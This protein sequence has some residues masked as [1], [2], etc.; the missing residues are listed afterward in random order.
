MNASEA[1]VWI[2]SV[3]HAADALQLAAE[4]RTMTEGKPWLADRARKIVAHLEAIPGVR[5]TLDKRRADRE[6]AALA[7]QKG[8][9]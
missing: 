3:E 4:I 7:E 9:R 6:A 2:Q 5:A 1:A 8:A